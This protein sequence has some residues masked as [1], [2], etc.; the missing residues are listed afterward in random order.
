MQIRRT[1]TVQNTNAINLRTQNKTSNVSSEVNAFPVDQL[2]IS[3]EAQA[4]QANSGIRTEK[5]AELKEQ[6]AAGRYETPEKIDQAVERM[7]DEIA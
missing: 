4:I 2:D 3:A 1:T 5:V 7:L 6:I